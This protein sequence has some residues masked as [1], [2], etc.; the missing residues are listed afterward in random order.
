MKHIFLLTFCSVILNVVKS[1]PTISPSQNDEYCPDIEYTF[2]A[3]VSKPFSSM[4]GVGG[5][6]LTQQPTPP[7]GTTFTFKGKFDDANQK[8]TFRIFH[9]DA[10]QTDFDFKKIK[11]LVYSTPCAQVSNQATI[12]VP[13]CQIVNIPIS[14]T[15]VQWGTAFE[16]PQLCFG[17]ITNYE[18]QLPVGWSIGTSVST[19]SNWIAGSNSVT[20]TSDL[21]NGL[22]GVI[23]VRPRNT[24]GTSLQ[25]GQITGQIPISRPAPTTITGGAAVLCSGTSTYTLNLIP[26]GASVSWS[27]S[28]TTVA[29][30]PNPS[31][32]NSVV[33]TRIGSGSGNTILTS[34]V[35]DCSGTYPPI[36][37]TIAVGTPGTA[38]LQVN[39][40]AFD[41]CNTGYMQFDASLE[42]PSPSTSLQWSVSGSGARIK[43][44][45][46]GYTPVLDIK[47][48]GTFEIFG[49]LTN[50]CGTSNYSSGILNSADFW[51]S[52]CGS[53]R[54]SVSPNPVKG[55]MNV[56]FDKPTKTN[57]NITMRLYSVNS[58]STVKQ[59]TLKGGQNQFNLNIADLK[60]GQYILEVVIGKSK[61][62]RQLIIE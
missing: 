38:S 49:V 22:N 52:Y 24:C 21:S 30:I 3:T 56:I 40:S 9:P 6:F 46:T 58:S 4:I 42:N 18:Y 62:S 59:W 2:T 10:S 54:F 50:S 57:E 5:C 61:T 12:T 27:L 14:F 7:V 8:Q 34:T 11:S 28:N 31:T 45:A 35:S 29:S 43:F 55:N 41:F 26:A 37:F 16:S 39:E 36:N 20:V 32:G 19:G 15:N 51:S 47:T 33:V 48:S 23:L 25:N 1:Q 53:Y 13:R 44:S 60:A 17:S